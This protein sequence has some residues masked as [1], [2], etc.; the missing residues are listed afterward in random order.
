MPNGERDL[1]RRLKT[2]GVQPM[3]KADETSTGPASFVAADPDGNPIP[4]DQHV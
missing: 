3:Q 4:V 1:I 2:L